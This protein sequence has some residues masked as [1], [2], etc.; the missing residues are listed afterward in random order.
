MNNSYEAVVST[1]GLMLFENAFSRYMDEL[2][3]R[4]M[5]I[6]AW[7]GGHTSHE[8]QK[9]DHLV[10]F[11][12]SN[13][14]QSHFKIVIRSDTEH[15]E[16]LALGSLAEGVADLLQTFSERVSDPSSEQILQSLSR[17]LRD[18][19]HRIDTVDEA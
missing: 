11:T 19:F 13:E 17:D 4:H 7:P 18:A 15:V 16:Q 12:I 10:S 14:G 1:A 6:G 2:H 8:F 9:D 3:F 5:R